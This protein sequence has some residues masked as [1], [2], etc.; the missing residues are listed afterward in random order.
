VVLTTTLLLLVG[1][2][3]MTLAGRVHRK[4]G[5]AI[6]ALERQDPSHSTGTRWARR[7]PERGPRPNI[8]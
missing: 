7:T 8:P 4:G 1:I 5:W 6:V 3:L 2:L